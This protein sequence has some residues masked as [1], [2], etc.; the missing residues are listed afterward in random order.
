MLCRNWIDLA[1]LLTYV[2]VA[3]G[4]YGPATMERLPVVDGA[5]RLQLDGRLVLPWETIRVEGAGP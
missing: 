3:V 4:V 1:V 2:G 5:G